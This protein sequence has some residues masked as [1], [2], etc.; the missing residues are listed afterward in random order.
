LK[1]CPC[2]RHN[3]R[4]LRTTHT[5]RLSR[6]LIFLCY[7]CGHPRDLHSFPTRRSSD[8]PLCLRVA[9]VQLQVEADAHMRVLA[10]ELGRQHPHVRDRKSTRL[11]SSHDQISYAVFC[12][13]KKNNF[14]YWC[15]AARPSDS[16]T[17]PRLEHNS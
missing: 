5:G 6:S 3:R 16:R 15:I 8:L 10:R 17:P 13:K 4:L 12:L 2:E 1:L 7:R 14:S 9:R 11:N